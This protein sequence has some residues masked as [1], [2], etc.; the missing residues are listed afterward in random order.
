MLRIIPIV[1]LLALWISCIEKA[2]PTQPTPPATPALWP[3]HF[4]SISQGCSN[5]TAYAFGDSSKTAIAVNANACALSLSSTPR[6]FNL[7]E[8]DSNFSVFVNVYNKNPR[9]SMLEFCNDAIVIDS[10]PPYITESWHGISG[11]INISSSIIP[12]CSSS[13]FT[14]G[15]NVTITIDSLVLQKDSS[16]A[17]VF[18]PKFEFKNVQV[19]WLPG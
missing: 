8:K 19:G 4:D 13:C 3:W 14:C 17:K 16:N 18:S 7:A 11:I 1:I 2:A 5:F 12:P 9:G 6:R 10:F 15:Y